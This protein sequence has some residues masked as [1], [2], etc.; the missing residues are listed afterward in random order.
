MQNKIDANF[1]PGFTR[2]SVTFTI[3]DGNV[4]LDKKFLDIVNPAGLVGAFNLVS[5]ITGYLTPEEYREF[6]R[7][8]EIANHCKYHPTLIHDIK[9]YKLSPDEF[10][11][12]TANPEFIYRAEEEGVY[13]I[14]RRGCWNRAA[15]FEAYKRLVD[16]S[17]K[18]LEEIFG[19]GSIKAFVWPYGYQNSDEL[20]DLIAKEGYLYIRKTGDLGE[21]NDF[22]IV[23]D[24]MM[25]SY[26][27]HNFTMTELM[28]KYEALADDGK[29]KM[30]AFGVHSHD[31]E[32]AGNWDVLIDFCEKYGNRPEDFWYATPS[33]IFEYQD[34]VNA[35]TVTDTE[36]INGSEIK[37]YIKVNGKR[38]TLFPKSKYKITE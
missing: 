11:R 15:T 1:F 3:D 8:H 35:L 23:K 7:G 36:I 17:K 19:E 37:L 28:A 38:V 29:L 5:S 22:D 34:A 33:D 26:T 12:E 32:N 10:D 9:D 14:C 2:K 30:F 6:Y 21:T 25:W 4:K 16:V 13:R 20:R 31:F 18:E 27:A 24:R